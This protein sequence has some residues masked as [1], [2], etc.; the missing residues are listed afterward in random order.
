MLRYMYTLTYDADDL[1]AVNAGFKPLLVHAHMYI[2]GDK[3]DIPPLRAS[4]ASNLSELVK[5]A[6]SDASFSEAIELIYAKTADTDSTPREIVLGAAAE[7]AAELLRP[8]SDLFQK[9]KEVPNEFSIDLASRLARYPNIRRGEYCYKCGDCTGML[10]MTEMR[11][12]RFYICPSQPGWCTGISHSGS[13]WLQ[14][15]VAGVRAIEGKRYRCPTCGVSFVVDMDPDRD[16]LC[17]TANC[18]ARSGREWNEQC[19]E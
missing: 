8:E 12:D 11:M 19:R 15:I 16:C 6:W 1:D 4:A 9:F 14:R 17:P 7:H 10:F 2:L 5:S 13:D 18:E 3:Y